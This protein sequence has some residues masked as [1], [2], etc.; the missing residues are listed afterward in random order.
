[1][2]TLADPHT[3]EVLWLATVKLVKIWW[4]IPVLMLILSVLPV[5]K[6]GNHRRRQ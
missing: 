6:S 1:M 5:A 3:W 2:E 4:P